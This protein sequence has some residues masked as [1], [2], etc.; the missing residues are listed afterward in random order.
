M[1]IK[2]INWGKGLFRL[3]IIVSIPWIVGFGYV[4]LGTINKYYTRIQAEKEVKGAIERF[5]ISWRKKEQL[6]IK[7]QWAKRTDKKEKWVLDEQPK[8]GHYVDLPKI[9]FDTTGDLIKKLPREMQK[10]ALSKI[11]VGFSSL[12]SDRQENILD[13]LNYGSKTLKDDAFFFTGLTFIPPILFFLMGFVVLWAFRGF[14][15]K[16]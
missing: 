1:S 8:S 7:E 6:D 13:A 4:T 3:W 11:I 10:E 15:P 2:D 14:L 9:K 16:Q 12:S 5:D